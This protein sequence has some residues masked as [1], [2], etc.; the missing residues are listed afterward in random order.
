MKWNREKSPENRHPALT[1]VLLLALCLVALGTV[2]QTAS[3]IERIVQ[4][5]YDHDQK[6]TF[7]LDTSA[8]AK[9]VAAMKSDSPSNA[10]DFEDLTVDTITFNRREINLPATK[11]LL[12]IFKELATQLTV[13][14]ALAV[15]YSFVRNVAKTAPFDRSNAKYLSI[16]SAT[17]GFGA[18]LAFAN[19][20]FDTLLFGFNESPFGSETPI[21]IVSGPFFLLI[22]GSMLCALLARVFQKGSELQQLDEETI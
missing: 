21:V 2:I 15:I 22:L 8:S 17:I 19:P 20:I 1:T 14:A 13:L 7:A 6:V 12:N 11:A 16:L 4:H 18:F 9:V 3:G 10:S 5:R